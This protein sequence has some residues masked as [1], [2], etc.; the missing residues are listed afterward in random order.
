MTG[1]SGGD[2]VAATAAFEADGIVFDCDG[3]L[4]DSMPGA[5]ACWGDWAER[6]G[7][8]AQR[9]IAESHGQPSLAIC[10]HWLPAH[11]VEAG[12]A[13]I[14]RL[15]LDNAVGTLPIRGAA[16]LLH[17]LPAAVPWGIGTSAGRPLFTARLGAAGLPMP[18]VSVTADDITHGKPDPEVYVTAM[19]R[20]GLDPARAIVVDDSP[21]GIRAARAA[22]A[23]W[24]VRVGTGA[25]A[26]GEDAV[27][28]DLAS[29]RWAG[30]RLE[31]LPRVPRPVRVVV[32]G[33][34]GSGKTTVAEQLAEGLEAP[35][36][37]GDSVHPAR[38]VE[39]MAAGIP[40]TDEDRAP[41]LAELRDRMAATDRLVIACSALRR[42]YRDVL[43]A[44]GDVVFLF[45][46]LDPATAAAR[47]GA[48]EGHFMGPS[49]V[50]GQFAALE[51]PGPSETDV[52]VI[53]AGVGP[54]EVMDAAVAA[55]GRLLAR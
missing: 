28:P 16:A 48:R 20:L 15:E 27:V 10:R 25:P 23:R 21:F 31:V 35:F 52:A 2:P 26:H 19:R 11:Q 42:P 51:V 1:A 5:L 6:L 36:L 43:R 47:I 50:A 22:G 54:A 13:L 24:V 8:D 45:L 33:V 38:N 17:S 3:V 53:D 40:L 46:A 39:R 14:D 55:V 12:V 7:L 32:A 18:A 9:V 34:A 44:A 4:V 41:W 29:L 49:M 37:D 30:D